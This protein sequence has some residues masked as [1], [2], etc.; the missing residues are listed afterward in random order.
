MPRLEEVAMFYGKPAYI[1]FESA[2]ESY[3]LIS[4]APLVLTCATTRKLKNLK[5]PL[6]EIIFHHLSSRLFNHYENDQG[7]LRATAEKALLDYIYI[8]IRNRKSVPAL[9]EFNL[10]PLNKGKARRIAKAFPQNVRLFLGNA[11]FDQS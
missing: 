8:K 5:T 11:L 6:G 4:Q 7:I 10:R 2:L 3:G 1:S 9:D